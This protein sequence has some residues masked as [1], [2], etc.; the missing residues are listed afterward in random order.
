LDERGSEGREM[1]SFG[2]QWVEIFKAGSHVADDGTRWNIG[3][4]FLE[5]VVA[6]HSP[7]L[8]DAPITIGHP[9]TDGPAY[10]W[11]KELRVKEG[12]LEAKF[13]KV[14]PSFEDL[15]RDGRLRKRSA[16]FYV[17]PSNAPGGKAPQLRHVGFLGAQ[18]PAV[19]GLRDIQFVD[20][21]KSITFSEEGDDMDEN[22]IVERVTEKSTSAI[23][24]FLKGLFGGG[25]ARATSFSE[26]ELKTMI[27]GAVKS[28]TAS[29]GEEI[30]TLKTESAALKQE[31]TRLASQVSGL[32]NET[33]KARIAAFCEKLGAAKFP[34]AF[35]EMGLIEFMEALAGTERKV[36]VISF[37]EADGKK[38]EKK[39]ESSLLAFFQE[40][41]EELPK[42]VEFGEHYGGVRDSGDGRAAV[43]PAQHKAM[44]KAAG[45]PEEPPK[46]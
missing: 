3:A 6:N 17:D 15:V 19:K 44:R 13:D 43:D 14:E 35:R 38:V 34:P 11:T 45:L 29:F 25:E 39:T 30:K 28:A 10:G 37:E 27:E 12:R 8:H 4:D 5:Q 42:F 32:G 21:A 7:T 24:D 41:L 20:G 23:K 18:P 9:Q 16:A 40:F 36:T 31:N 33:S 26:G 46:K 2:D 1:A 22:A